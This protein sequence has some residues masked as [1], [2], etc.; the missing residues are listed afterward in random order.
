MLQRLGK[1][2]PQAPL[3][4]AV[5]SWHHLPDAENLAFQKLYLETE[6]GNAG[7]APLVN[8]LRTLPCC[9]WDWS[10]RGGLKGWCTS[11]SELHGAGVLFGEAIV[12][13]MVLSLAGRLQ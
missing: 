10:G 9:S 1:L 13:D 6:F 12:G 7:H 2:A 8:N 11:V 3:M 5:D 4:V